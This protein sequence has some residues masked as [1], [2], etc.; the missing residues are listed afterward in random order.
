MEV[1]LSWKAGKAVSTVLRPAGDGTWRVRPPK[2]QKIAAVRSQSG[3]VAL[4]PQADGSVEVKLTR[5][6]QY[7]VTFA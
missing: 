1:D 5:G 4:Q 3:A 2:G 7:R 6:A